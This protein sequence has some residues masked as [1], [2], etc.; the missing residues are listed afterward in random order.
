M[1]EAPRWIGIDI[2]TQGV[3]A[4]VLSEAAEIIG[5]G[6]APLEGR[7]SEGRHE[8]SAEAWWTAARQALGQAL[9][10]LRRD[11]IQALAIAATSGTIVLVDAVGR[12]VSPGVMYDDTRGAPYV[13]AVNAAGAEQWQ[14]MGYARMQPAWALPKLLSLMREPGLGTGVRVLHQADYVAERLAGSPVATDTSQALKTG[15]DLDRL[16]WPAD[17][18]DALGID[19]AWM[20]P[21]VVPGTI[22]GQ[23]SP[24]A[25]EEL[26]LPAGMAIVAGMTDSCAAQLGAG[27][28]APGE[29]NSVLGTTLAFKGVAERRVTD[30]AGVLYSHRGLDGQWLPG[31]ASSSGAG[32]V[33]ER[34]R[35][36]DLGLLG[37]PAAAALAPDLF[38][39]PL[40]GR[41]ERFP[42]VEPGAVAFSSREPGSDAEALAAIMMGLA[43]VERLCFEMIESLGLPVEGAVTMTGGATSNAHWTQLR[44]DVLGREAVVPARSGAALGMALLAGAAV[45]DEPL[46]ALSARCPRQRARFAPAQSRA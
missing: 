19:T 22:I 29:W 21:L 2:G 14:A 6:A 31:G 27:A 3:R 37:L 1:A 44:A 9:T 41:G 18:L 33:T 36:R 38:T 45:S 35:G 46:A 20:P 4:T 28:V 25:A 34:L 42:F 24:S 13:D 32:I 11:T 43:Y 16:V 26:G 15:C 40:A 23:V 12:P 30:P 7:R 39:Y 5:S 10:G 8:Q 17:V